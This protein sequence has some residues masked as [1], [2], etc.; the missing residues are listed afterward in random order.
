M[1]VSDFTFPADS[2]PQDLYYEEPP[3]TAMSIDRIVAMPTEQLPRT[4]PSAGAP[5]RSLGD[6]IRASKTQATRAR[7]ATSGA[8]PATAEATDADLS[9]AAIREEFAM[10]PAVPLAAVNGGGGDDAGSTSGDAPVVEASR[11]SVP[12]PRRPK[13]EWSDADVRKF[14]DALS[15]FGTDFD[16]IAVLFTPDHNRGEV[17]RLYHRELRRHPDQ[18]WRAVQDRKKIDYDTFEV[19]L[20]EK[21]E[22]ERAPVKE[23]SSEQENMLNA[24]SGGADGSGNEGA[25][26]GKRK[27]AKRGRH[28][29]NPEGGDEGCASGE[30][31]TGGEE[32]FAQIFG[33]DSPMA[34]PTFAAMA[35][36]VGWNGL[37]AGAAAD[38]DGDFGFD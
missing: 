3:C 16:A 9:E 20:K 28:A 26:D 21:Q 6:I 27:R 1:D 5:R 23:I 18:V 31:G 4:V 24:M 8:L 11:G 14:Y 15:Q 22:K 29:S 37:T 25:G 33:D 35:H 19:L 12:P 2:A 30:W 13:T 10:E 17:K 32:T 7:A 36:E 38:D 34:E